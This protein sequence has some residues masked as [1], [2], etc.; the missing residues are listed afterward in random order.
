MLFSFSI[1]ENQQFRLRWIFGFGS[2]LFLMGIGVV[3]T[4]F[5]QERSTF[6]FSDK[7]EI[8]IGVVTDTPQEKPK[9]IAYRV[10]LEKENK[11]IVC[12]IQRDSLIVERL[13][14]GDEFV[15]YGKIQPFKNMGNPDDFGYVRYM[16]NQGFVGSLYLNNHS[17]KS[18]GNISSSLKSKALRCRQQILDFYKSLGFS[19][20]EYSIL[21]ALTLGYKDALT[22]DLTQGF[23]TT[24][25]VHVLS[26]SGL[27]VGIIYLMISF[28]LGFIRKGKKYY[29]LKPLLIII[30]LWGYAFITGLPISVIRASLMLSI[31]CVG[32]IFSRKSFSIHALYIAAFFILLVNPFA[33][34]DISFQLSFVSVLAIL[35]LQPRAVLILKI[36]NK[37]L[38]KVWQLFT[39][40]I[41]AQIGTFPLCLYYFGTFP[42][43]F[44]VTNIL[45]VPLVS[46]I[47]YA[48]GGVAIAK[49]LSNIFPDISEYFYYFPVKAVQL[50]VELMTWIIRFFETLPFAL[51]DDVKISF[52]ELCLIFAFIVSLIVFFVYRKSKPLIIALVALL[53]LIFANIY[54]NIQS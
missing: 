17:W 33:L 13:Q 38:R 23:R 39:L 32:E 20:T 26:V 44:F 2:I 49:L 11:D 10:H 31:F 50:L 37:Y 47:I 52:I 36:E 1:P 34:F 5:M 6:Q 40:S 16:Y 15:F 53:L 22:D 12:Y 7:A 42:T 48:M 9:T 21:S 18:T 3:S 4:T 51:I 54:E 25:T 45:I 8:Y 29:W 43:Y 46:L 27:H 41:V 24:G 19:E 28:L 30:L 14:P 35:Y